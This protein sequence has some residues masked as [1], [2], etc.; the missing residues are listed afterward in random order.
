MTHTEK[1]HVIFGLLCALTGALALWAA[2]RPDS[3]PSRAWPVLTF[4]V[5]FFLFI[6]VEAQTRTYQEVGW[7]DT[8]LSAVPDN[9]GYWISNWFRY[10]DHWHVIQHKI[11]GFLIMVA[12]TVEYQRARGRL[13]APSWGWVFPSLLVGIAAAFG[14]HGGSASHLPHL[15]EQ[16]H[17]WVFGAALALAALS[18]VAVRAGWLRH[19]AARGAWAA[20]VLL[21]GLDLALFYRLS[22]AERR[23]P[24]APTAATHDHGG[25]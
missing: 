19:P 13:A 9:A 11:G 4:L 5:G 12:G 21:V 18:L 23:A 25:P 17:H 14:V 10:L 8:L 20:L 15:S 3:W 6:P 22:P 1:V 24:D 16:V 7:W 2:R